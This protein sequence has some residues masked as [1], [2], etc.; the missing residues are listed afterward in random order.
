MAVARVV[1]FDG[2][3][4]DRMAEMQSQLQDGN[5]PEGLEATE[6]LMLHDPDSESALAIIFFDSDDAY[7]RGDA[8]MNAMPAGDTPGSRTSVTKYSVAARMKS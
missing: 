1:A 4:A 2:V 5:P 7:E 6:F 3:S 8:I